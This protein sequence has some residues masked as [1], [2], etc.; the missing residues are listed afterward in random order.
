MREL[1]LKVKGTAQSTETK[2]T[3]KPVAETAKPSPE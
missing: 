3:Q 1:V 2:E